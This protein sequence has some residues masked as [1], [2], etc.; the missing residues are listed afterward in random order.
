VA[1]RSL[2][3]K[4]IPRIDSVPKATGEA[5]FTAD[6]TLP[7]MLLGK[8]LRGPHAAISTVGAR[9]AEHLLV[10]PSITSDRTETKT[11]ECPSPRRLPRRS[12]TLLAFGFTTCPSLQTES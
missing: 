4:P 12:A 9:E 8:V 10:V 1:N 2:V 5:K 11:L 7:R 6:L 3:G